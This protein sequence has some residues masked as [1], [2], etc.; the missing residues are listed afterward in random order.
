MSY[1]SEIKRLVRADGFSGLY[2]G[3]SSV[4]LRDVPFNA[5]FYGSYETICTMLIR[6]KGLQSKDDLEKT[7]IFGAGGFAG[8]VGWSVVLPFD[9]AK[10]RMQ[11]GT[12]QGSLS[13]VLRS[14]VVNEGPSAL[15]NGWSA[16][17][18]RA[19]PANAGLFLGVEVTSRVLR[20]L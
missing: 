18:A 19:F 2:K 16:A 20:D 8:C 4:I 7:F 11:S 12:M 6:W 1:A 5:L 3:L 13:T 10:T 17:V 14:I 15:F 9:V